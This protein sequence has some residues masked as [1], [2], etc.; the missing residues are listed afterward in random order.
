M[1]DSLDEQLRDVRRDSMPDEAYWLTFNVG[2]DEELARMRSEAKP[3]NLLG[4]PSVSPHAN[5]ASSCGDTPMQEGKQPLYRL[6]WSGWILLSAIT[7]FSLLPPRLHVLLRAA[8]LHT[9]HH[10]RPVRLP[11]LGLAGK[12]ALLFH[13]VV[14]QS[15]EPRIECTF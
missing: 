9:R 8:R 10:H 4:R 3:P 7:G 12:K 15:W 2:T 14:A 5:G 6:L 13:H 11:D 1:A